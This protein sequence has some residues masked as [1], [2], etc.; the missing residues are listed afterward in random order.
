MDDA[1]LHIRGN[2]VPYNRLAN[3]KIKRKLS[4]R[5][6]SLALVFCAFFAGAAAAENVTIPGF[7]DPKRRIEKPPA[8]GL[9]VRF[10]TSPDYTPFNYLNGSGELVGFNVDLARA[11]CKELEIT[12]TIQ[13]RAWE[14][15]IP[16]LR[17]NLGDA[18]ISGFAGSPDLRRQ[19]DF[20]DTYFKT[21]ARFAFASNSKIDTS[22]PEAL[23][24]KT[25]GVVKGTSH[26]AFLD[27]YYD[28]AKI[29]RFDKIEAME[30]ALKSKSV[31]AAFGD[32][33][34]LALWLNSDTAGNC[35]EFR[36]GPYLESR[37]FGEGQVIAVRKG[38]NQLRRLLNYGLQQ[39]YE[40]G[41][42][43]ELYLKWFPVSVF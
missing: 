12:C 31:E 3:R 21:P 9:M 36:G 15:L 6:L 1:C 39:L 2:K 11:L 22:S 34:Q 16:A 42:Y 20:T 13:A 5:F 40:K 25:I 26:A 29:T 30:A 24:G 43:S 10:L 14:A 19:A 28:S 7:W 4:L 18:L 38:Q 32:G 8:A 37:F 23:R 27:F 35:C 41:V 33:V 17:E